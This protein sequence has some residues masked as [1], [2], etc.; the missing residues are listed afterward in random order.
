MYFLTTAAA[1]LWKGFAGQMGLGFCLAS[2]K[3]I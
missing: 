3:K 1:G 2:D